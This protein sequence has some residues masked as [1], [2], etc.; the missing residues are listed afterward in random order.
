LNFSVHKKTQIGR[1]NIRADSSLTC[2]KPRSDATFDCQTSPR[3][4]D[5]D[6]DDQLRI[7]ANKWWNDLAGI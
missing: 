6:E 4:P 1:W 5:K 7:S 3:P 2:L